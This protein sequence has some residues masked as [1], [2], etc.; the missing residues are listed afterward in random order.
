MKHAED[1][2]RYCEKQKRNFEGYSCIAKKIQSLNKETKQH[3]KMLCKV[4]LNKCIKSETM[5]KSII[6]GIAILITL[7][8][9]IFSVHTAVNSALDTR[10][11]KYTNDS[12]RD[13]EEASN[14]IEDNYKFIS[15]NNNL[16]IQQYSPIF[17][18]VCSMSS[19]MILIIV[20]SYLR[21]NKTEF[22]R[23]L[24]DLFDLY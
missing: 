17:I 8:A 24:V 21:I 11:I 5:A 20:F 7:M 18:G 14:I 1:F 13:N 12:K 16:L 3:Y 19:L 4:K 10:M 22:Y 9:L 2:F 6:T 23:N 15:S